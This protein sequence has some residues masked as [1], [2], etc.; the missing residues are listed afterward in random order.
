MG[1]GDPCMQSQPVA[2]RDYFLACYAV[3]LVQG[4]TI[5]GTII[6]YNTVVH[7]LKQAYLLFEKRKLP[8]VSD[9]SYVSTILRAVKDYEDVKGRRRMI[10]DSMTVWLIEQAEKSGPDSAI[11]AIVDWIIIGRYSGFRS[12]EWCQESQNKYARIADWPGNPSMAVTRNDFGHLDKHERKIHEDKLS[13]TETEYLDIL[14]RHQKNGDNG[15]RI[16]FARDKNNKKY[17]IVEAALRIRSCSKRLGMKGHEPMG[18]YKNKQG[19]TKFISTAMVTKLLRRAAVEV[20]GLSSNDREIKLWSSHSIRVTAA[21]LLHRQHLSDTFI[22][23]RLR[24]K[25]DAF[26]CYLRNT[27]YAANSHTEKLSIKLSKKDIHQASYRHLAPHERIA[28]GM[29]TAKAA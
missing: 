13:S 2:A 22:M 16:V 29:H 4:H 15:Q 18:V 8:F 17:C 12:S 28:G 10:T 6:K 20:L 1:L 26:L 3:S 9:H 24:W 25:S 7:Y 27:I 14:W 19:R 5:K 23:N 21:N 11:R